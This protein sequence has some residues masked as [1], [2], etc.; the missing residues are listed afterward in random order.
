MQFTAPGT[1]DGLVLVGSGMTTGPN[2]GTTYLETLVNTTVV[3]NSLSAVPFGLIA[4]DVAGFQPPYTP[5]TL[6]VVGLLQNGTTVTND[7]SGIGTSFQT[8]HLGS[9]FVNLNTVDLTGGFA[10][11]NIVV[12]I[13]EP[14]TGVLLALGTLLGVGY[15]RARR[16]QPG[17]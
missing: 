11:D 5:P 4:F 13:P 3:L 1:M 16:M 10:F 15:V 12:G 8:V 7:F 14:S 17:D 9:G 6:Q 2:D